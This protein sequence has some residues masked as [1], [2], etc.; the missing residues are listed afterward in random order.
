MFRRQANVPRKG[1][2]LAFQASMEGVTG[3]PRGDHRRPDH[4]CDEGNGTTKTAM[5]AHM[6]SLQR[7]T[8][9]LRFFFEKDALKY[10]S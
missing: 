3:N 2:G 8:E 1:Q 6:H 10:E 7:S 4:G 5:A 9:K